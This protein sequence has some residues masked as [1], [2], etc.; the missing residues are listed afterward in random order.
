MRPYD[1]YC[2]LAKALD[3]VGDRWTLLIIRELLIRSACRF[4]DIRNGLPGIASNLLTERLRELEASGLIRRETAPPPVAATVYSLT[5]RG[6]DVAPVIE[7]LGA[8]GA[9][10][11]HSPGKH[12]VFQSHWLC[13]PLSLELRD[14]EPKGRPVTIE[15]R[16][17]NEPLLVQA[18]NGRVT[19][20]PGASDDAD[21]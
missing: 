4:T 11:L 12:D 3:V 15:V 16:A 14:S 20:R 8:F 5:P 7:A 9:R 10:M 19:A 18:R 6:R 17:G 2:A 1:Q 21:A 13:L